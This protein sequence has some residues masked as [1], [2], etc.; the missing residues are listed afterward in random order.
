MHWRN[1]PRPQRQR[2]ANRRTE[3]L[4]KVILIS[5]THSMQVS[6]SLFDCMGR[7]TRLAEKI[8]PQIHRG[9]AEDHGRGLSSVQRMSQG[10]IVVE[11][12]KTAFG[13][14]MRVPANQR[15][16]HPFPA[17][18]AFFPPAEIA[19]SRGGII[20]VRTDVTKILSQ[21]ESGDPNAAE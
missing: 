1:S 13:L 6:G 3:Y 14:R 16:W 21:I 12:A 10:K 11:G 18:C 20:G 8:L 2:L 7:R 19:E 17:E 15:I 4:L 5:E 9:H